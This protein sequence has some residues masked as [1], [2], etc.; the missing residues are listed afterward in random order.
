MSRCFGERDGDNI[1]NISNLFRWGAITSKSGKTM[2]RGRRFTERSETV[3]RTAL[4]WNAAESDD[5]GAETQQGA[6]GQSVNWNLIP[7]PEGQQMSTNNYPESG[8]TGLLRF[9]DINNTLFIQW[10][11]PSGNWGG[12]GTHPHYPQLCSCCDW[13][14]WA[15]SLNTPWLVQQK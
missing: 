15:A 14:D 8:K 1:G 11:F 4:A 5:F 12:L 13:Q 2:Y 6:K 10:S 3:L 9:G 7:T